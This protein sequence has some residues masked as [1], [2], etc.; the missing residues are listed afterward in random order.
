MLVLYAIDQA[1]AA[2]NWICL[3]EYGMAKYMEAL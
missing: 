1:P 2:N 3:R